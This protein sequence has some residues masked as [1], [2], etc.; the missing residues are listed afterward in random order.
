MLSNTFGFIKM[1]F[2]H[3]ENK[4]PNFCIHQSIDAVQNMQILFFVCVNQLTGLENR[5]I[6]LKIEN[7]CFLE[8]SID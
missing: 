5:L 6:L 4:N 2:S 1:G 8:V 7:S 3:F